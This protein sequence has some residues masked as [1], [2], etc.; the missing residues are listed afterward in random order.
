VEVVEGPLVLVARLA[1]Q[2][3]GD[4]V[5]G[6]AVLPPV[7]EAHVALDVVGEG[8]PEAEPDEHLGVAA[9]EHRVEAVAE[10]E[11]VEPGGGR[12]DRRAQLAPEAGLLAAALQEETGHAKGGLAD[13]RAADRGVD[14]I[15]QR[16]RG[17]LARGLPQQAAA[18]AV[19]QRAPEVEAG[20]AREAEVDVALVRVS[21]LVDGERVVIDHERM[22][23]VVADR[24]EV[25]AVLLR[26]DEVPVDL[27]EAEEEAPDLQRGDRVALA[28]AGFP[29]ELLRGAR[30]AG[31]K[32]PRAARGREHPGEDQ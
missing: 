14:V 32:R 25:G 29:V 24:L 5:L 21:Q 4:R 26:V 10:D 20:R 27:V 30:G 8:D 2:P 19:G 9:G 7:V 1:G 28:L 17:G 22:G 12:E 11:P 15:V 18:Q 6:G 13:E 23:Q 31:R 3:V 16:G